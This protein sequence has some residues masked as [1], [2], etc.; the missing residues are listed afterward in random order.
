MAELHA[1]HFLMIWVGAISAATKVSILKTILA[2]MPA[3]PDVPADVV[4]AMAPGL[5]HPGTRVMTRRD[6]QITWLIRFSSAWKELPE[7]QRQALAAALHL[8][9][10]P[11]VTMPTR[12]ALRRLA[13]VLGGA[14]PCTP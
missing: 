7:P 14:G 6:T 4:Q 8:L 13:N 2:W 10:L 12:Q 3:P 9:R 5:V 11:G 1:V